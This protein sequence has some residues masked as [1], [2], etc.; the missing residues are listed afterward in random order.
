MK[1]DLEKKLKIKTTHLVHKTDP[2]ATS[3]LA[4][5]LVKPRRPA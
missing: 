3:H 1:K 4:A 2:T 5:I